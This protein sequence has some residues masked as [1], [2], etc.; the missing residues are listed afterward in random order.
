MEN[1][2]DAKTFLSTVE[3][4]AQF[5]QINMPAGRCNQAVLNRGVTLHQNKEEERHFKTLGKEKADEEEENEKESPLP[6]LLKRKAKSTQTLPVKKLKVDTAVRKA[7][8]RKPP[9][10]K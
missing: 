9:H 8:V 3:I 6:P 5:L 2:K 7:S 1:A 4:L 10:H